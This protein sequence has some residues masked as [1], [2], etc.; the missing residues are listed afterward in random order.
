MAMEMASSIN[1]SMKDVDCVKRQGEKV[2][3]EGFKVYQRN[4][5]ELEKLK[6]A[7]CCGFEE[8]VRVMSFKLPSQ[9]PSTFQQQS[10]FCNFYGYN[11]DASHKTPCNDVH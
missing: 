3:E 7:I 4:E 11:Y 5:C 6:Q 2:I 9:T 10:I 8:K 1:Q